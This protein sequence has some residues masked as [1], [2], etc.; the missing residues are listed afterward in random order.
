MS[1]TAKAKPADQA[2]H[3][4]RIEPITVDRNAAAM[5]LGIA[6]S[7]L[8][9]HVA[10]GTLPKPRQLGGR[11]LWLVDELRTTAHALPVSEMLP[12]PS[13]QQAG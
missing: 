9:A 5:L 1:R 6:V 2:V 11:A 3:M 12:P 8:E 10:R 4:V 13:G 7:T